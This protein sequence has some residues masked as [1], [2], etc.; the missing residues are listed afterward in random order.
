MSV[1]NNVVVLCVLFQISSDV[2]LS[3]D[4]LLDEP[5][6]LIG[7]AQ[8]ESSSS[9][10]LVVSFD[11]FVENVDRVLRLNSINYTAMFSLNE[12]TQN[13]ACK[14][15][16]KQFTEDLFLVATKNDK[17][18]SWK[19]T[20]GMELAKP[21]PDTVGMIQIP[22][23]TFSQRWQT[24]YLYVFSKYSLWLSDQE[25]RKIKDNRTEVDLLVDSSVL[26]PTIGFQEIENL[27]KPIKLT[28]KKSG[29][30]NGNE[31]YACHYWDLKLGKQDS[32][33]L[34]GFVE[35]CGYSQVVLIKYSTSSSLHPYSQHK[36]EPFFMP[37]FALRMNN[38]GL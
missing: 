11:T 13:I 12:T 25:L 9:S 22:K 24:L 31:K 19:T 20:E 27:T 30:E 1:E 4:K 36:L 17:K 7:A 26:S 14:L 16:R 29:N 28:F 5:E 8:L 18:L 10:R 2:I 37:E 3:L 35:P 32:S 23:E 6:A 38:A 21:I 15:M 33:E 34:D